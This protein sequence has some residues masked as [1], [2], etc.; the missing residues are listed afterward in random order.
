VD[1]SG[2][3]ELADTLKHSLN[4]SPKAAPQLEAA[5][6][7][8]YSKRI[9]G[10]HEHDRFTVLPVRLWAAQSRKPARPAR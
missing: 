9:A 3:F 10:R 8:G 5:T 2:T 4:I 7:A 6:L 1:K